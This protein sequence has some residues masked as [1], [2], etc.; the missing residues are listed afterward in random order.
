MW[1]WLARSARPRRS[2]SHERAPLGRCA[3]ASASAAC[4]AVDDVSFE[5]AQRRDLRGDRPER[6]R[7][8]HAVQHDR[9]RAARRTAA[10]SRFGGERIDGLRPDEICRRGIGRTF[11]IVRPFPALTRR[12]QRH[13]RRAAAPPPTST[14][15]RAHARRGAAPARPVR[16]A[17]AARVGADAA[18]PQA[19][20]GRARARDRAEAAAA[21]RGDGGPAADRD[22]PHGRDPDASSTA[23]A[24]S[25][26]C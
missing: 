7:Q 16:Q 21:R 23:T 3:S 17:H 15:A 12:G 11:Q 13:R 4:V 18:R 5:V 25:P 24:A 8:D 10:R 1:P 22:R 9:R 19:A 20:R 2:A 26:S 6:R 14:H